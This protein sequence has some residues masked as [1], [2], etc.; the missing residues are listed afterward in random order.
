MLP[1]ADLRRIKHIIECTM[2][3]EVRE[4]F[5]VWA[6]GCADSDEFWSGVT[7]FISYSKIIDAVYDYI[8][9][10]IT[11]I[12]YFCGVTIIAEIDAEISIRDTQPATQADNASL[13]LQNQNPVNNH[14]A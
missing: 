7:R 4:T 1:N 3:P 12:E 6:D 5:D 10:E 13:P 8:D 2:P 9:F 14:Q 11:S